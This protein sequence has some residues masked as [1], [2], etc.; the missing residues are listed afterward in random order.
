M[1]EKTEHDFYFTSSKNN[2]EQRWKE[3]CYFGLK[4]KKK[5][6]IYFTDSCYNWEGFL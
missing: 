4:G 2:P 1:C 3:D 5:K 6:S